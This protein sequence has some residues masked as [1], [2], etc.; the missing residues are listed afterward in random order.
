MDSS[1]RFKVIELGHYL[2]TP[3]SN[4]EQTNEKYIIFIAK[5]LLV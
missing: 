1:F 5:T 4:W 3:Y 2:R